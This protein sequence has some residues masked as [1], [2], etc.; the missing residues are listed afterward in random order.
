MH[1]RP[2]AETSSVPSLRVCMGL[3][4]ARPTVHAMWF[5]L[6]HRAGAARDVIRLSAGA[7]GSQH[8]GGR[9]RV[10]AHL[11]LDDA[12]RAVAIDDDVAPTE[13]ARVHRPIEVDDDEGRLGS[14]CDRP[15]DRLVADRLAAL[16]RERDELEGPVDALDAP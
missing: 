3:A 5:L 11:L 13:A 16:D 2:M 4:Y 7:A 1:P 8:L 12:A 15:L 10:V 9:A 6:A 14:R